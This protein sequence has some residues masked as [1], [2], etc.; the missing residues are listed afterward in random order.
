MPINVLIIGGGGREHTLAWAV[1]KSP[2]VGD[3]WCAPGNAGI[4]GTAVCVPLN[5]K[6]TRAV[7]DFLRE[8]RIGLT[9]VGPEAPLVEGLP[10]ALRAAGHRVFGP[11]AAAARLEGSKAF[12]KEFMKAHGIPTAD[13]RVFS[14]AGEALDFVKSGP[15][16]AAL[17]VVKASGLAAGKGVVVAKDRDG[18]LDALDDMMVKKV[19]GSAGE[20]VVL[21]EALEGEEVSVLALCDG[22]TLLPLAPAQDH[23]RVF[24]NDGGP[25]TG[26]M[27]AY[28][29]APVMTPER[30]RRVHEKVLAPTIAG[31]KQEGFP[32][33]GILY[34]GII[35][36]GDDIKVLEFN[37]R[38]GDPEAQVILPLMN[39]RLG[40]IIEGSITGSL[41]RHTLS[42]SDRHAI[43]VVMASAGYPGSYEKGK[44]IRGL[45]SVGDDII[46]FHAGTAVKDGSVITSGGR[47]LNVTAQGATLREARD[48]VY[49]EIEKI[50]FEGAYY[51]R[52]IAYRALSR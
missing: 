38:F 37:V 24:D 1:R 14:S 25:N 33:K 31:M 45:D 5:I 39:G 46:V 28:A 41:D 18:V 10:D 16:S 17:R 49:G 43:T 9:V 23:K 32:F 52:D 26:G 12:A 47:V 29:P 7:L 48:R 21:E 36:R 35:V 11:G 50:G 42:F 15:W 4:E 6:D 30:L 44:V 20:Q 22:E 34:A 51:R 13:F 19:F 8:K 40:D 27:G 2:Q 3:L